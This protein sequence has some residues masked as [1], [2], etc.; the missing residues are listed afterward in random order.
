MKTANK[1]EFYAFVS[2]RNLQIGK[3]SGQFFVMHTIYYNH[4]DTGE[5]LARKETSSWNNQTIYWIDSSK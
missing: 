5:T 3:N 2:D 1:D 4:P